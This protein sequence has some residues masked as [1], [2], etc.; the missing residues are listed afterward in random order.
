VSGVGE[1]LCTLSKLPIEHGLDL[2][3][4]SVDS[5]VYFVYG[6]SMGFDLKIFLRS[7]L[8]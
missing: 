8:S 3:L 4:N 6:R 7:F 2:I 1:S 5:R